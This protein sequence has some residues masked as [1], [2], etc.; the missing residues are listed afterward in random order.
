METTQKKPRGL[1]RQ[2][3]IDRVKENL[4]LLGI[5]DGKQLAKDRRAWRCVVEAAKA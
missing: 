5:K 4:K 2:R 1:P 3:W